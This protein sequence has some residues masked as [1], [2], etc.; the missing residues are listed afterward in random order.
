MKI[1]SNKV[2]L[3]SSSVHGIG[4]FTNTPLA[5]YSLIERFPG[6]EIKDP[7]ILDTIQ[8]SKTHVINYLHQSNDR[9]YFLQGNGSLY[10]HS[11]QPNAELSQP[12]PN[13]NI[14]HIRSLQPIKRGEEILI[15]YGDQWQDEHGARTINATETRPLLEHLWDHSLVRLLIVLTLIAIIGKII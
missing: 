15:Y 11:N 10:N 6:L 12:N 8:T 2:Y 3:K 4:V 13:A 5:A 7:E 9:Y 1:K 14:F